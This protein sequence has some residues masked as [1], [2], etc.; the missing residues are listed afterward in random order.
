M[1]LQKSERVPIWGT[2]EPGEVITIT[3]GEKSA[4]AK[5]DAAGKW[6]AILNLAQSQI[7]PFEL[8]VSGRNE[9]KIADVVVGEV[10][11]AIEDAEIRLTL[12]HFDQ[13]LVAKPLPSIFNV[14]TLDHTTAP[15]VRNSP[16]ASW[17]LC[18]LWLGP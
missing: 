17:R 10:W 13:G 6:K 1:V 9:I 4:Q 7:G 15:L 8:I 11:L 14:R 16:G 2:A 18:H 5:A 3:L 12:S